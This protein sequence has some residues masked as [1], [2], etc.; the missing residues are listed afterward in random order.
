MEQEN[1][2]QSGWMVCLETL[3][4]IVDGEIPST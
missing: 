4:L 3:E 1:E 2:E